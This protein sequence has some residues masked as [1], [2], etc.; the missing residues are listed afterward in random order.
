MRTA[1]SVF[2]T[3]CKC[4]QSIPIHL[5]QIHLCFNS[6]LLPMLQILPLFLYALLVRPQADRHRQTH[7]VFAEEQ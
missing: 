2:L 3:M 5:N 1:V 4:S 7:H 6:G